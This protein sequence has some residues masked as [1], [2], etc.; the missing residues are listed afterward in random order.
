MNV[1]DD[2]PPIKISDTAYNEE[3]R[4]GCWSPD[5]SQIVFMSDRGGGKDN[6][7]KMAVEPSR[8]RILF[9]DDTVDIL[10]PRL[11]YDGKQ[12][13]FAAKLADGSGELRIL[14]L[15]KGKTR[16][17][18]KTANIDTFPAWSPD[19]E[20]IAFSSKIEGNTEICT[21][22][23]DGT[24][25]QNLTQDPARDV[26]PA[27]SPDG[28]QL[29]FSSDR[30]GGSVEI[31]L[32]VMNSDGS[33]QRRVTEKKGYEMSPA[34]TPD[35]THLLFA[36]DRADGRSQG[37]DIFSLDLREPDTEKILVSRRFHDA[38]PAVSPDGKRVAFDSQSDG[39]DEIYLINS[40]GSGLLR[41]TRNRASDTSP[42]FS[43]DGGRIIFSSNR[44]GKSA[45]FEVTI[46]D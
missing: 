32:F 28:K 7:Y 16:T 23:P 4:P 45:I 30:D 43:K 40:D 2:S 9:A 38:S 15:D 1:N 8:P 29:V 17:I 27:W 35:G 37:L 21:I 12:I 34:W 25:L 33:S 36:G 6:I 42:Q 26:Y 3:I 31:H 20:R 11:S 10:S 13:V 22:K 14:D 39:N 18:L 46:A 5:G 44:N 41:L 24:E 19:G